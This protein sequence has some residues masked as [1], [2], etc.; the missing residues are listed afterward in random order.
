[1][2]DNKFST[3]DY[4]PTQIKA[5]GLDGI[6]GIVFDYDGTEKKNS[7]TYGDFYVIHGKCQDEA[8]GAI[9]QPITII[10]SSVKLQRILVEN[11]D[12]LFGHKLRLTGHG[13]DKK[14]EY[15]IEVLA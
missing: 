3:E 6:N 4:N 2:K 10:F 14:R 15:E 7:K 13:D 11:H 1:M 8:F 9:G 12:T 5:S